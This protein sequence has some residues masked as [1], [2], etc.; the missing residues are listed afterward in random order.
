MKTKYNVFMYNDE[1]EVILN[2]MSA[3]LSLNKV[4]AT[5]TIERD[6]FKSRGEQGDEQGPNYDSSQVTYD[7]IK[8]LGDLIAE[9]DDPISVLPVEEHK[10]RESDY[11]DNS[12]SDS[13]PD[14][15][16]SDSSDIEGVKV[17]TA[18]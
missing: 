5:V 7:P 18:I 11:S 17:Y 2:K 3:P 6:S 9:V 10:L 12:S 14:S 16:E 4:V 13:L 1:N 8:M 15:E